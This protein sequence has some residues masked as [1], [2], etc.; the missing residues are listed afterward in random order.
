MKRT[1]R[2]LAIIAM[3]IMIATSFC[4]AEGVEGGLVLEDTYP[5]EGT[6]GAAIENFDIKLY[7]NNEMTDDV[8]GD[9]NDNCFTLTD[10]NGNVLPVMVLYSPKETGVVMVL[11]DSNRENLDKDGKK[12]TIQGDMEYTLKVSGALVDD[13]GNTLGTDKTIKFT[14]INQKRNSLVSILL[15]VVLYAGII[16]F[17]MKNAK[18]NADKQEKEAK[19]NPYKEAKRTGKS[20]EEIMEKENKRQARKALKA[21]QQDDDEE[22]E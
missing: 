15:M 22:E 2:I 12:I 17:S 20:V 14:T 5:K 21:E 1:G 11:F 7:F 4:F 6:S 16:G 3:V 8:L 10:E 9:V 13:A 18:K 19:F